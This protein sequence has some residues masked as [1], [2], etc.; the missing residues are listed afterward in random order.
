MKNMQ[1]YAILLIEKAGVD[2]KRQI[3]SNRETQSH[4]SKKLDR[5]TAEDLKDFGRVN[6]RQVCLGF[7]YNFYF[8]PRTEIKER[9]EMNRMPRIQIGNRLNILQMDAQNRKLIFTRIIF[10]SAHPRIIR[11]VRIEK[12]VSAK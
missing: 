6:P 7:F 12:E 8:M 5:Q 9:L 11:M 2:P 10:V 4:V 3:P 1:K